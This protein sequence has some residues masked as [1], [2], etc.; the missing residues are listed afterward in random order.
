MRK[1]SKQKTLRDIKVIF[2]FQSNLN[3][4]CF[5]IKSLNHSMKILNFKLKIS[6]LV[7]FLLFYPNAS[8][9]T[10]YF[11]ACGRLFGRC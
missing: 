2:N 6:P 1:K 5:K 10:I 7:L 3:L 11:P 9:M 8:L 4:Q